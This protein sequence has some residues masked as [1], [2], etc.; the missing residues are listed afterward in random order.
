MEKHRPYRI[1]ISGGGT[2]GHIYPAIAIANTL[3]AMNPET[4]MLFV[5]AKGRMEMQ[6]VPEAGY[7]IIGLWI[8]GIQRKLTVNNLSF[9]FKLISSLLRSGKIIRKFKPDVVIGVGGFASGP[10]LYRATRKGIPSLIQEQ[11]SFP[12]ITNKLL[13]KKVDKICVADDRMERFFPKEKIVIT[14]NPVRKDIINAENKREEAQGFF[15][16]KPGKKTVLVIGGSNGARTINHSILSGIETIIQAGVQVIWQTGKFYFEEVNE[17]VK[18]HDISNFRILEFLKEMDLAYAAA[19]V[20]ISRAGALSIS[21]LCL[22]GKPVIF[23]PSPNVAEDHQTKNARA[24]VDKSAAMLIKDQEAKTKLVEAT[25]ALIN[26]NDRQVSLKE[27]ISKLARPDAAEKIA[28]EI[29][30]LIN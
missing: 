24:L 20:V 25:L 12:G 9:P 26:D 6:K 1:I 16:L 19:D 14:G 8:S 7:N 23:V 2:G 28:T 22:V 30:K 18:N 11:N 21:E 5:G 13:A 17:S 29:L 27:N 15:N 10:L 3:K 4:E